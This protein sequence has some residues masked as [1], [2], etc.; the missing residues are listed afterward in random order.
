MFNVIKTLVVVDVTFLIIPAYYTVR[1]CNGEY[2]GMVHSPYVPWKRWWEEAE[3][4]VELAGM[5]S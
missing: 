2:H 4:A 3:E 1:V 5:Y